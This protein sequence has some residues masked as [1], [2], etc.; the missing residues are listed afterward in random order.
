MT[1]QLRVCIIAL[2]VERSTK[3]QEVLLMK[4]LK[5]KDGSPF[6]KTQ[7]AATRAA[8]KNGCPFKIVE[9]EK[10]FVV[11]IGVITTSNAEILSFLAEETEKKEEVQDLESLDNY[12]KCKSIMKKIK[13]VGNQVKEIIQILSLTN[14][15]HNIANLQ[16]TYWCATCLTHQLRAMLNMKVE[17]RYLLYGRQLE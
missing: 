12:P 10:G 15:T 11:A 6:F 14:I 9:T 1:D 4:F 2:N 17:D 3:K 8:N 7:S 13:L 5:K 16:Y